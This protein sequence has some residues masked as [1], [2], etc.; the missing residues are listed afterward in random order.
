MFSGDGWRIIAM[1]DADV[2]LAGGSESVV[3]H[4]G[5]AGFGAAR[6]LSTR[7]M[8]LKRPAALGT[9]IVTVLCWGKVPALVF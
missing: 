9:K 4:L 3:T 6:A 1:G 2:M 7:K 5:L 8:T